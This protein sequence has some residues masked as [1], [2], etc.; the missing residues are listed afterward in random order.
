[1]QIKGSTYA[2]FSAVFK[3]G[4]FQSRY[5]R[6]IPTT[7]IESLSDELVQSIYTRWRCTIGSGSVIKRGILTLRGA[8]P[9]SRIP[10]SETKGARPREREGKRGEGK[11]SYQPAMW[12]CFLKEGDV[13]QPNRMVTFALSSHNSVRTVRLIPFSSRRTGR[14]YI[15]VHVSSALS[16]SRLSP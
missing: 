12:R 6:S 15:L 4:V 13:K 9:S 5:R 11:R 1:M 14:T 2:L 16:P 7:L 10:P 3:R 8:P